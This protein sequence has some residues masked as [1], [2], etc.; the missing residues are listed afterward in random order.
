V[1]TEAN[2]VIDAFLLGFLEYFVYFGHAL[3]VER[4]RNNVLVA[5]GA[6]NH[7]GQNSNRIGVL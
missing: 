6:D 1:K 2:F 3:W 7:R 4:S 5:A